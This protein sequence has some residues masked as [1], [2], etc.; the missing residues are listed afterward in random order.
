M[1]S[2]VD[3]ATTGEVF[4]S[5]LNCLFVFIIALAVT[6]ITFYKKNTLH[7]KKILWIITLL[8]LL[9]V[10]LGTIKYSGGIAGKTREKEIY[11]WNIF[12]Y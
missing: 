4:I 8:L 5:I 3:D 10:P 1:Q 9:I 7:I 11:I 6:L 2:V 12:S